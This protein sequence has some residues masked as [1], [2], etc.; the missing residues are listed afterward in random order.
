MN[1]KESSESFVKRL[2]VAVKDWGNL[3]VP[4][5]CDLIERLR[6]KDP[7]LA[8][9]ISRNLFPIVNLKEAVQEVVYG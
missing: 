8:H 3:P 2:T 7:R 6:K 5:Q 4:M 1:S 9:A